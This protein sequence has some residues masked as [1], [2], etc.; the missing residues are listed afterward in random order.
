MAKKTKKVKPTTTEDRVKTHDDILKSLPKEK[1]M[2]IPEKEVVLLPISGA[3]KQHI[4]DIMHYIM[5]DMSAEEIIK[6]FTMIRINFKDV[7]PEQIDM[8]T[9][10]LWTLMSMTTELNFQAAEQKKWV[11]TDKTIGDSLDS[12]TQSEIN[13]P[14]PPSEILQD[15]QV[16]LKQD[17]IRKQRLEQ[18][19]KEARKKEKK[20]DSTEGS[21]Q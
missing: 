7:E 21:P 13:D 3:F 8:R 5:S 17:E 15:Q 2:K 12:L 10:S 18:K 11:E 9:K 6:A 20:K 1:V 4:D 14:P 19:I 16:I